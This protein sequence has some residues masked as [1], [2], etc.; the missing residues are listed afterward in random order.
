M[1][2]FIERKKKEKSGVFSLAYKAKKPPTPPPIIN[3]YL[4]ITM[5]N[6]PIIPTPLI[7]RDTRVVWLQYRSIV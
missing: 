7:I 1:C 4:I 2:P 6:P 3:N 5:S